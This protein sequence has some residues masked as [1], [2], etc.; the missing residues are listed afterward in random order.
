MVISN[1][2]T[3]WKTFWT[4]VGQ[5]SWASFFSNEHAEILTPFEAVIFAK[6]KRAPIYAGSPASKTSNMEQALQPAD[7]AWQL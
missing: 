6:S 7:V 1:K 4:I 2:L 5:I 3:F